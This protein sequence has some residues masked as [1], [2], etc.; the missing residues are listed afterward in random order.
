MR[1]AFVYDAVYPYLLGGGEKRVWEMARRLV[2][3]GHEVHLFGMQFWEGEQTITREG[4]ILHGVCRPYSFYRNGRRRIL[5]AFIFGVMVFLALFRQ[6]FDVV[7]CQ[8]F[9]Y[10]SVFGAAAACRI[11]RSPFVITWYE[12]WG[13]YWY[14]YLGR[15]GAGG[16]VLERLA[17]RVPAH[18]VVIS[19]TTKAGLVSMVG[20]REITVLPIGIDTDGI[21][22]VLPAK[23]RSDVLF[24]GRLIRE[25]HVDVLVD[26]VGILRLASP[27]IRC[28]IIGDGPERIN[29]E[30]KVRSLDLSD[31]ILFTGFLPRSEDVIAHMKS[32]RVFVLPSTR[33]GFGIS[34]L[35]AL[36]AG[37]PVVTIDHPKNASRV[38]ARDGCGLESSLD[39]K[40]LSE[41]IPALLVA[42]EETR[43]RCRM[44]AREYDWGA[45]IGRIE[46]YYR[47]VQNEEY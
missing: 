5:P 7:D 16:K 21:D 24:A 45:I 26:A 10:T 17:A 9:P 34:V 12:V 3:R 19:E 35:E 36:A 11:S 18:T 40:D 2:A 31:N 41:R 15:I 30:E 33:E 43:V 22:S 44:K 20:D 38:F 1:I 25:K 37:I 32:S 6:R 42:G 8:Q 28:V 27:G 29:L 4:V 13:D 14:D 47:L 39:A 23:T 46:E